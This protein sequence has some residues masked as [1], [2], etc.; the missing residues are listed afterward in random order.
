MTIDPFTSP[1]Q[2]LAR[3]R[4]QINEAITEIK[5][6]LN[7]KPYSCIVAL[8][9][10]TGHDVYKIQ[11]TGIIPTTVQPIIK[12][13][14]S[15]IRDALDHAVY[16]SAV[17]IRSGAPTY[18]GFPFARDAAGVQ[19]ELAGPR[20]RDNPPEIR[21]L[22]ASFEPHESGNKL[23]CGLNR[24]RNPNTH[25]FLVPVGQVAQASRTTIAKMQIDGDASGLTAGYSKWNPTT[26]EVE[27]MRIPQGAEFNYKVYVTFHIVF[28]NVDMLRNHEVGGALNAIASEVER[29]VFAIEAETYRIGPIP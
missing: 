17:F 24:I 28:G 6:F 15:N 27:F 14:T 4:N 5:T 3:A 10:D 29:I 8:D 13:V 20:L 11:W 16:A 23:L 22:L 25:R 12:D 19:G 2:L 9:A 21:P 1:K 18:T 7:S 26:N